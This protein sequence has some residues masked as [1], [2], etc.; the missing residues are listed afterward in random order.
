[1]SRG[2]AR[3]RLD[4]Y[5]LENDDRPLQ[6]VSTRRILQRMISNV[7]LIRKEKREEAAAER[8]QRYLVAL[9]R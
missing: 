9:A 5:N 6:P 1:M 8:L 7:H 4:H 3:Q 2:D